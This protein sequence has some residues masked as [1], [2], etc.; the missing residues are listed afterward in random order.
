MAP[1]I[2]RLLIED[3]FDVFFAERTGWRLV[4]RACAEDEVKDC[5]G[6]AAPP[7]PPPVGGAEEFESLSDPERV[8]CSDAS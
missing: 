7:S 1:W 6:A 8:R 4:A 2:S 5:G 3:L